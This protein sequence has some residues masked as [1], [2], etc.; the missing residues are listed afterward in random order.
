MFEYQTLHKHIKI[1]HKQ[2]VFF[3]PVLHLCIGDFPQPASSYFIPID[4]CLNM[5]GFPG[6]NLLKAAHLKI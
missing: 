1:Y 2:V 4:G 3:Y 5:A 6:I